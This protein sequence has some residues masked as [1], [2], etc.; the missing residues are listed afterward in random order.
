MSIPNAFLQLKTLTLIL[1]LE[2]YFGKILTTEPLVELKIREKNN[3][4]L[5]NWLRLKIFITNELSFF[6]KSVTVFW[7]HLPAGLYAS[8]TLEQKVNLLFLQ[9]YFPFFIASNLGIFF[10]LMVKDNELLDNTYI[11]K[12]IER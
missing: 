9:I 10:G 11:E 3:F 8:S 2:N 7:Q 1:L 12:T 5:R 4:L 6:V